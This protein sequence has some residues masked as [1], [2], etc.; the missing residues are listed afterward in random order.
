VQAEQGIVQGPVP[1]TPIQHWFFEQEL[2]HPS[3][4]NQSILLEIPPDADPEALQ[5]AVQH[6]LAHHDALRLR[7]EQTLDGWQQVNEDMEGDV[8]FSSV[9]LSELPEAQQRAVIEDVV[10]QMQASL[11]L[12]E[13][14][15]LRVGL[16]NLGKSRRGR[17]FIAAHHLVIDGV[18]W[19]IL[20]EDFQTVYQQLSQGQPVQLPPKTTSFQY[21]AQKLAAHA[22]SE[23][24]KEELPYWF[25]VVDDHVP[26]LPVDLPGGLNTE[27]STQSVTVVLDREETQALLT[28][29]P[30]AYRTEINDVL[31]TALAQAFARW[32][33]HRRVHVDLE[34]HGREDLFD[35]VDVSRT[36]GWFTTLFPVRLDITSATGPGEAL[37]AVKEQLR[38]IP[39]RGIGFGLLRYLSLDQ[40]AVERLS[41]PYQPSV[42]F[43]Y[44][45]QF[46][47]GDGETAIFRPAA[48]SSGP[49][50]HLDGT[51]SHLL[52][53]N[54]GISNGQLALEWTY[55]RN[56]HRQDTIERV[57]GD[58]IEE[59]RRLISHC[60]SPEA[61]AYTASDFEPF[62]WDEEDL[63]DIIAEIGQS[64]G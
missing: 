27:A 36:V 33:G 49:D 13:G 57:A 35:D 44:L 47:P 29:V 3:H 40:K 53:I 42:S 43:N 10:A 64:V 62:G 20:L 5:A 14:P 50:R 11:D 30:T 38:E 2:I 32:T 55:S 12:V 52:D 41:N 54:G 21:W 9:D 1:L 39:N 28:D 23:E 37:I 56:V 61:G 16:F 31:L 63:E 25:D 8:P 45:G 7:Y 46:N 4:W 48:E 59:L 58:F 18:S 6:L 51:R 60:Q 34:G 26:A 22:G 19:R 17:L 24:L 15:L